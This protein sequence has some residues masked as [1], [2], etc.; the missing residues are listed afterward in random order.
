MRS[1]KTWPGTNPEPNRLSSPPATNTTCA[2]PSLTCSAR[3]AHSASISRFPAGGRSHGNGAN[4]TS[5]PSAAASRAA[6][7]SRAGSSPL[8][9]TALQCSSRAITRISRPAWT[10]AKTWRLLRPPMVNPVS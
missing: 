3:P 9:R 6:T 8:T 1:V 4:H 5:R 10:G 7:L 2:P